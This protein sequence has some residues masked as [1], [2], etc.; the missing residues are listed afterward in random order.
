MDKINILK[1]FGVD[2]QNLDDLCA[3]TGVKSLYFFGSIVDGRFKTGVSD[4]DFLVEFYDPSFD[5]YFDL[6]EGLVEL[7]NYDNIDLV[8]IGSLKNKII[9]DEIFAARQTLYAA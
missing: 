1:K 9:R 6:K 4:L 2:P 8:T 5:G 7:F 3:K